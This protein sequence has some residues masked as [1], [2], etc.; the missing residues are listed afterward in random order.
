MAR[1]IKTSIAGPLI[2]SPSDEPLTITATGAIASTAAGADEIDGA[3]GTEWIIT[4]HGT[5]SS[6]GADGISLGGDGI[7]AN[8]GLVSGALS[9]VGVGIDGSGVLTNSG[10]TTGGYGVDI[11]GSGVVTNS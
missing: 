5:V 11:G 6:A 7:V 1:T 3:A 4:N 2:L 9:G 8:S 10:T